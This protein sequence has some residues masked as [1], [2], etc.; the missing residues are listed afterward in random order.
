[1]CRERETERACYR[2]RERGLTV[3]YGNREGEREIEKVQLRERWRRERAR[4]LAFYVPWLDWLES[5][6]C[7]WPVKRGHRG[8]S[9]WH[10]INSRM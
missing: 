5:P 4:R 1:M 7:W 9:Y 2:G 10:P 8:Q 3:R 6:G